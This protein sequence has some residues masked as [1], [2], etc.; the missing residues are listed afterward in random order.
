MALQCPKCGA[1]IAA[2]DVNISADIAKCAACGEVL[3][4][5][6]VMEGGRGPAAEVAGGPPAPDALPPDTRIRVQEYGEGIVV[7]FPSAGFSISLIFV[8]AFAIAW[9]SFLLTFVGFGAAAIFSSDDE[10]PAE[11][12]PESPSS[13]DVTTS[14]QRA[15]NGNKELG[16]FFPI[17]ICLFLTPFFLAGFFMLFQILWPL[18]GRTA[19]RLDRNECSYRASLFGFGRTRRAP[20]ASTRLSWNDP[21]GGNASSQ[22]KQAMEAWGAEVSPIT[23]SLGRWDGNIGNTVGRTEQEWVYHKLRTALAQLQR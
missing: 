10:R 8:L 11:T 3:R 21:A 23:L 2:D 4:P 22:F 13:P 17:F 5:S 20:P 18:F 7:A 1:E 12:R 19:V 6:Q 15:E 16:A 9:W 14:E